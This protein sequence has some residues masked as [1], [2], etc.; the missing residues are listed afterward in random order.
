MRAALIVAVAA[1][2]CGNAGTTLQKA[3]SDLAQAR[4]SRLSSCSNGSYM[5]REY[6]DLATCITRET[7]TCTIGLQAPQTGNSPAAVEQCVS[8]LASESCADLFGNNPPPECITKGPRSSGAVC[9]FGGQ[10]AST[11]CLN[12]RT[13][14]CGTCGDA[15]PTGVSCASTVCARGDDCTLRTQ[16]CEKFAGL[17]DTCDNSSLVCGA[18]L[19]CDVPTGATTS[20]CTTAVATLGGACGGVNGGC[21]GTKGITCHMSQCI[22][23]VY[24]ADGQACGQLT[25]GFVSCNA[26][27]ECYTANGIAQVGET[28]ICKT[29]A[30][31]GKPCDTM[32]GPPCLTPA[33]CVLTA[34]GTTGVCTVANGATCG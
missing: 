9:T 30:A 27:G 20:T 8:A 19:A 5:T 23:I 33:R 25:S 18:D 32:L 4:C 31:D 29:A 28:G 2:G 14:N 3:C 1:L 16:T 21:D 13:A 34:G 24:A 17:G 22:A 7:L 11:Y 10:C 6:G 26:G 15:P 12:D